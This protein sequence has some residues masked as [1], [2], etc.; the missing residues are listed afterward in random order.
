VT[1]LFLVFLGALIGKLTEELVAAY[2][3][4]KL[5]SAAARLVRHEEVQQWGWDG[6]GLLR[7]LIA[8]DKK[9]IGDSLTDEREG[10]E[11]QWA[12]VFMAHPETW[13]LLVKGPKQIIGYLHFV[14]LNDEEFSRAKA[15]EFYDNR[16]TLETIE[17]LDVPGAYNLYFVL[18]GVLPEH[19][20]GG[21]RLIEA[22]FDQLEAFA[23][24]G[25]FF[26]EMCANAYT[27]NGKRLC[28][29][30]G[31]RAAGPHKDFGTVYTL[32]LK[33][34]PE[35]MRFKRWEQLKKLYQEAIL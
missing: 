2:R 20:Y 26:R 5:E 6:P 30:F 22:F 14:A 24:R 7:R 4:R 33:E 18:I 25:I 19:R 32:S 15:G 11:S 17:P 29:G 35:A 10:T 28:E 3:R 9:V 12:P 13:V 16:L 8:L 1:Q 27:W 21:P 34:W 23:S 31:M